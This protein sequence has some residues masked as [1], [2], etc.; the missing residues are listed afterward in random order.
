MRKCEICNVS[1]IFEQTKQFW[2]NFITK[3]LYIY[4]L[5]V[6]LHA[7]VPLNFTSL[8][9]GDPIGAQQNLILN[10]FSGADGHV[11][12]SLGASNIIFWG[13]SGHDLHG[14]PW[15]SGQGV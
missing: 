3:Y 6:N 4:T 15:G 5:R 13:L 2:A 1:H 11:H 10:P 8:I 9:Q 7:Q 12:R 14:A